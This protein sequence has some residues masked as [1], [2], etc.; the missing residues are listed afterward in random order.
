MSASARRATEEA[1]KAIE[2]YLSLPL[3][4]PAENGEDAFKFWSNYSVT[5]NKAQ[6]SLCH[7]ARIFLTPPPTSTDVERLF[8]TAGG[9]LNQYKLI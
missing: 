4:D 5:T 3:S 2:D 1:R 6:K 7:L 8:S 9:E